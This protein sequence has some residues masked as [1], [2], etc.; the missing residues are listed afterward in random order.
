LFGLL[1]PSSSGNIWVRDLDDRVVVTFEKVPEFIELDSPI[2]PWPTS[3][4]PNTVQLEMFYNGQIRITYQDVM[5]TNVICGLSDGNGVPL[6]LSEAFEDLAPLDETVDLSELPEVQAK[7]SVD[8]VAPVWAYAGELISF[9]V[10]TVSPNGIPVL[11]AQWDGPIALPFVDKQD[12]T[13]LFYWAPAVGQEGLYTMRVTATMGGETAYQ[14]IRIHV[15]DPNPL[16]E[17]RDVKLRSLNTIEDPTRDRLVDDLSP[18]V[19]EYTYYHPLAESD[20][21]FKEGFPQLYWFKDNGLC[22]AFTNHW[23]VPADATKAGEVWFFTVIPR[24][25]L[26]VRGPEA[27]SPKVTVASMP[28]I[29]TVTPP[30]GPA[31]GA[32]AVILT[33]ERLDKPTGVTFGGIPVQ[34]IR[35]I[36]DTEIE[37]LTPA[38]APGTVDI[39][40]TTP[41]GTGFSL[42]AYTYLA[43]GEDVTK[44]DI[45]LDGVVDAQDVQLVTN[46]VLQRTKAAVDADANRDGA[47]DSMDIQ[48]VVFYVLKK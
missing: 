25:S 26:G 16:P 19:A 17:A 15:G 18:L 34:R 33:G 4:W 6:D 8:P 31:L 40:V 13:G 35:S 30:N 37:V 44:A 20:E 41:S 38:H 39:L 12:G 1:S 2:S 14:D 47:V 24:T 45:N 21:D 46:A 36:S 3:P 32:T 42:G 10:T 22:P 29:S 23:M 28:I 48:A 27:Y 7:L 43:N 5:I 9:G 11:K